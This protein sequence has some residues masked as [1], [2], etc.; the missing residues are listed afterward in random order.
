M[1]Q[2]EQVFQRKLST[3]ELTVASSHPMPLE[4]FF[5]IA[6]RR[7]PKRAFLFVSKMLGRHIPIKPSVMRNSY[8]SIAAKLP[9]NLPEP[10]L[11]I[12]MAETAVGLAAGVYQEAKGSF[13][14]SVLLTSTRHPI[15]GKLL[16]EFKE[17]HSHATDHLIYWPNEPT[18]ANRV[19]HAKSLVLIDDEA[20]TGNT[21]ANLYG[22][23][24]DAGMDHIDHLVAVTLTDW[25]QEAVLEKIDGPKV[26]LVSLVQGKWSWSPN[27]DAELPIMPSVDVTAKGAVDIIGAQNWGRLGVNES[28]CQIEKNVNALP[29]EKVLVIGTSE[30]VWI[31]FLMAEK[32]EL[33]GAEVYFSSTSRSPIAIGHAIESVITFTDNYG[34]GIPNF[35]YNIAH[36]QFDSVY[37]CCETPAESIDP[38]LLKSLERIS[39]HVEVIT[40]E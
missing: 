20:T 38:I 19:A 6:E 26:T 13:A 36:Q 16:C 18:L 33:Q 12:G 10:V 24:K 22:A 35:V 9:K 11:F 17:T 23:L 32:L 8:K 3:G 21:F 34:L 28:T 14:E 27:P 31:P 40:Y 7:N 29:T 15:D 1:H 2:T 25:S 37:L 5:E 30:F 39:K 4:H